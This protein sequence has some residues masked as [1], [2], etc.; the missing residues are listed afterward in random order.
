MTS[1]DTR[2]LH[3]LYLNPRALEDRWAH[4]HRFLRPGSREEAGWLSLT[5]AEL[6]MTAHTFLS[7]K[8]KNWEGGKAPTLYLRYDLVDS[9]LE[10]VSHTSQ[11]GFVRPEEPREQPTAG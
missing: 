2:R 8:P 11:P 9:I 6:D 3:I 1:T 10:V 5:C 7:C 4:L